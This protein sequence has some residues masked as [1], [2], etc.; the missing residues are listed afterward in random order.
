[1]ILAVGADRI[2]R[3]GDTANKVRHMVV[4]RHHPLSRIRSERIMQ[5]FW[6]PG[7]RFRL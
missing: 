2:A 4:F 3:N 1:M 6:R 7:I 5:Q